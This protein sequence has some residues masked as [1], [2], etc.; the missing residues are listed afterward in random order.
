MIKKLIDFYDKN[1]NYFIE[2][3]CPSLMPGRSFNSEAYHFKYQ[4]QESAEGID[5]TNSELKMYNTFLGRFNSPDPYGQYH[6]PYLGMGNNPVNG[7][8]PGKGFFIQLAWESVI[9]RGS[10]YFPTPVQ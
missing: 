8:D 3:Y 7:V 9:V 6:S 10:R 1:N 2:N 5:W 4:V